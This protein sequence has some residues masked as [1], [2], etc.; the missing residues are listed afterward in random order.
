MKKTMSWVISIFMLLACV[1]PIAGI[2]EKALV[3]ADDGFNG[4]SFQGTETEYVNYT[5]KT[6]TDQFLLGAVPKYSDISDH[7]NTCAN[8]AGATAIGYYDRYYDNLIPDFTAGRLIRDLYVY[9][10][11]S[12]A[13]Q[14]VIDDLYVRMGTNTTGDGTTASGFRSGLQSYIAA[15]GQ[16][17]TYPSVVS[18]GAINLTT[19]ANALDNKKIAVL[20]VSGYTLIPSGNFNVSS[21]QDKFSKSYYSGAHVLIAYGYRTEKYYN[22]SGNLFKEITLLYVATG[23]ASD[24][25][26]YIMLDSNTTLIEGNILNVY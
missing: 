26:V 19:L 9:Y 24:P 10:G 5:T 3:Y 23:F 6:E 20:F 1:F 22:A 25:L 15:H 18:G 14:D 8:T 13:V 7:P 12:D 17:I 4:A 11:H 2:A 16:N 21:T